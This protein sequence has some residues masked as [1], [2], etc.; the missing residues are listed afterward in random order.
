MKK[1]HIIA[2][3]LII[4]AVGVLFM[5]SNDIATY[6]TF[7]QAVQTGKKVK[8]AGQLMK[9]KDMFY[10]PIKDPNYFSFHLKDIEGNEKKVILLSSKPQDFEMSEQLVLTGKMNG[11]DFVAT[12][13]LMKCPSKYKDEEEFLRLEEG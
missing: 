10:D 12:D 8:V 1:V 5:A 4:I 2:I 13:M 7:D 11:D 3:V 9:E 6:S